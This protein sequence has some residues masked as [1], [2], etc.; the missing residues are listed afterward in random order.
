MGRPLS[1]TETSEPLG[2]GGHERR[3][4]DARFE[5]VAEE[6]EGQRGDRARRP[7]VPPPSLEN[8]V[9]PSSASCAPEGVEG[10]LPIM[11]PTAEGGM[12]TS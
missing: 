12:I 8:T 2:L 10:D 4:L 11:S 7:R 1:K 3:A 9:R 6:R 5:R